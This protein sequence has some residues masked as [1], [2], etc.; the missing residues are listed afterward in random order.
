M[1]MKYTCNKNLHMSDRTRV[2]TS[3]KQYDAHPASML[4]FDDTL[5]VAINDFNEPHGITESWAKH[6]KEKTE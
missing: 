1:G 3:G 4:P 2:F 5:F 6:F